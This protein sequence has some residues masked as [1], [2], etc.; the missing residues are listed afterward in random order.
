MNRFETYFV[1]YYAYFTAKLHHFFF[2]LKIGQLGQF[3][4]VFVILSISENIPL[5]ARTPLKEIVASLQKI[6]IGNH[7]LT[8]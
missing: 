2:F 7:K 6:L 1:A 4:L 3:D 8:I 5:I